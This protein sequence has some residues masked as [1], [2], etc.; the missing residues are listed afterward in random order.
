MQQSI[1]DGFIL[2][3]DE[4]II[5]VHFLDE[6]DE[7]FARV[8]ATIEALLIPDVDVEELKKQLRG[9]KPAEA[10]AIISQIANVTQGN[11]ILRPQLPGI[12]QRLPHR[13]ERISI[14]I[15]EE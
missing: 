6:T 8:R 13:A 1:P 3:E 15:T 10:E 4:Q 12:F 2:A 14:T 7:G 11:I 5:T 9:K